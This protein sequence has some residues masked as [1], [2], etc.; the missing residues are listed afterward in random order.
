MAEQGNGVQD[1]PPDE[2]RAHEAIGVICSFTLL[3][4][5]TVI[6]RVYTRFAVVRH[7]GW[8]DLLI[9]CA[10]I[11][12]IGVGICQGIET[13]YGMGRHIEY[14][15]AVPGM[16][17]KQFQAL[18]ASIIAYN[19]GLSFTKLSIMLQYLRIFASKS[20]RRAC[21]VFLGVVIL[22]GLWTVLTAIFGCIP[23]AY[24]WD[25]SIDGGKCLPNYILWFVNAG[26]NISTD[27]SLVILPLFGLRRLQLPRR[28]KIV[29]MAILTLGG[30][31]GV[32]S[33]L[34]LYSLYIISRTQ[35]MSWDNTDPAV[36]SNVELNIGIMCASLPTLRPLIA[37]VFPRLLPSGRPGR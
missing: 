17:E 35:D 28:Q 23:I 37:L 4:G 21:F 16:L 1:L 13:Q 33:I 25:R 2:S 10:M 12:S 15:A 9:V 11:A 8:E 30:F 19:F 32:T 6:L 22:Y 29:L 34:R 36:W 20:M 26:L 24:F 3:A 5:M 18:Y 7:S 27:F 31:A 14:V